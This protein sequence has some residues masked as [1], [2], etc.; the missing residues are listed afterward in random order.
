MKASRKWENSDKHSQTYTCER[1]DTGEGKRTNTQN[2]FVQWIFCFSCKFVPICLLSIQYI[3][4]CMCVCVCT[5]VYIHIHVSICVHTQI[6]SKSFWRY[7][8]KSL[9]R[10]TS[11]SE[12]S[13]WSFLMTISWYY[14]IS[15]HLK[16]NV[17]I[18]LKI[19]VLR[20]QFRALQ[21]VKTA[22]Q[23]SQVLDYAKESFRPICDLQCFHWELVWCKES[24]P[25]DMLSQ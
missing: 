17:S 20:W 7:H 11:P 13:F 6:Y 15:Y 1:R 22:I 21:F 4:K 10:M 12:I 19:V 8:Q 24:V 14:F 16:L 9:L 5:Y 3:S 2:F 23:I 18:L 25:D